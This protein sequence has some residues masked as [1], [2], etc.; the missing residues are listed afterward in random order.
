[1]NPPTAVVVRLFMADDTS[2][3]ATPKIVFWIFNVAGLNNNGKER[4]IQRFDIIVPPL[5]ADTFVCN[6]DAHIRA[7][8]TVP[9]SNE[10]AKT[11]F[12]VK[13]KCVEVHSVFDTLCG[14]LVNLTARTSTE[15]WL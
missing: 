12:E 10:D 2:V 5:G 9:D 11:F 7:F 4:N 6:C 13:G 8:F 3:L 15:I 14:I 1:M